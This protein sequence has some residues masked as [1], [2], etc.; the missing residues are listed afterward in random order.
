MEDV[1]LP[2][3]A[4][5][6]QNS[7]KKR[8]FGERTGQNT[9]LE[10]SNRR[11]KELQTSISGRRS[12]VVGES[13]MHPH[14]RD[15]ACIVPK[16]QVP[17]LPAKKPRFR[18]GARVRGTKIGF[19]LPAATSPNTPFFSFSSLFF[20]FFFASLPI[21]NGEMLSEKSD[22]TASKRAREAPH[23]GRRRGS[24]GLLRPKTTSFWVG[25]NFF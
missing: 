25:L 6:N 18:L 2:E 20:F 3:R 16:A 10:A 5:T 14:A 19:G 15:G 12:P 8:T 4:E 17:P 23:R 11:S 13:T 1:G 7:P 21:Q 9:K 24:L 22:A